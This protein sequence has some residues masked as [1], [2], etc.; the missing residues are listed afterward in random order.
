M[1]WIPFVIFALGLSFQA[2]PVF[3]SGVLVRQ[4]PPSPGGAIS[5]VVIRSTATQAL[6]SYTTAGT[7]ACTL[8]VSKGTTFNPANLVHDVDETLYPGASS[9]LRA[10]NIQNGFGRFALVGRRSAPISTSTLSRLSLALEANATHAYRI[11]CGSGNVATGAFDTANIPFGNTYAES[12][13]GDRSRPGELAQPHL[14]LSDRTDQIIDPQTGVSMRRITANQDIYTDTG[15]V[16]LNILSASPNWSNV[17]N[18]L[19]GDSGAVA[20]ISGQRDALFM[21]VDTSTLPGPASSINYNESG[22][23]PHAA[24]LSY[25]VSIHASVTGPTR[26]IGDNAHVVAS[27]T[28]DGHTPVPNESVH[29]ATL[30]ASLNDATFGTTTP[31][32]LWQAAQAATPYHSQQASRHGVVACDG[33]NK[34]TLVGGD[35]FGEHWN[36][37]SRITIAGTAYVISYNTHT[38]S[39]LLAASC[40]ANASATYS[41][42]NF[43]VL[44][45]KKNASADTLN[46]DYATVSVKA[47]FTYAIGE[48][49]HHY[50]STGTVIGPTGNPG[51]NC[52]FHS[53]NGSNFYWIDS[54]TGESHMWGTTFTNAFVGGSNI[55]FGSGGNNQIFDGNDADRYVAI[56]DGHFL[57]N[58]SVGFVKYWGTHLEPTSVFPFGAGGILRDNAL[59]ACNV[60]GSNA[61][62]YLSQQPCTTYT[63]LTAGTDLFTLTTNFAANPAYS[64]QFDGSKYAGLIFRDIDAQG[65]MQFSFRQTGNSVNGGHAWKVIFDPAATSNVELIAAGQT[66]CRAQAIGAFGCVG[67]G[68]A[69]AIVAAMPIWARPGCRFCED[70]ESGYAAPG[71]A[72]MQTFYP[73]PGPG[74]RPYYVQSVDGA[75]NGT[76][77]SLSSTPDVNCPAN[78]QGI[79]GIHCS[80]ITVTGEPGSRIAEGA[81]T[82]ADG[83]MGPAKVGDRFI[84]AS[85]PSDPKIYENFA[86]NGASTERV[87]LVA[88]DAGA[89]GTW[90]YTLL[91]GQAFRPN[92][93]ATGNLPIFAESCNTIADL[94]FASVGGQVLWNF[95][96]D[97][98]GMNATGNTIPRNYLDVNGHS[99]WANG[100]Y[101]TAYNDGVAPQQYK[102]RIA[103][104]GQTVLDLAS[105]R[106]FTS[107]I[108][109][110]PLFGGVTSGLTSDQYQTHPTNGGDQAVGTRADYF[111]D[112]RPFFGGTASGSNGANGTNPATLVAGARQLW[113]FQP[114]ALFTLDRK[115][116]IYP[117]GAFSGPY[118]LID[119]SGPQSSL[120][121]S[122]VDAFR[123][124]HVIGSGECYPGSLPGQLYVN[125]PHVRYPYS[126]IGV[127]ATGQNLTTEQDLSIGGMPAIRDGVQQIA[128]QPNDSVGATSR[129]ITRNASPRRINQFYTVMTLPNGLFTAQEE[130]LTGD[131]SHNRAIMAVKIPPPAIPDGLDRT[132]FQ[133]ITVLVSPR[134]NSTAYLRFGY[135]ENGDVAFNP[136]TPPPC[137]SRSE[138]C[139]SATLSALSFSV[140]DP[141]YYEATEIFSA[142]EC[143][144]GCSLKIPAISQRVLYYQVIYKDKTSGVLTALPVAV[145]VVA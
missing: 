59:P 82:G 120:S 119:V 99:F 56:G 44:I 109:N 132:T 67:G 126:Y 36:T 13:F 16:S 18:A 55:S 122:D 54:A 145:V 139:V 45:S 73:F 93:L 85:G 27:L 131:R 11:D 51:F 8:Q 74:G 22:Y 135:A 137:T 19:P 133:P 3:R 47:G 81:Q 79:T 41:A 91:R 77:N 17:A 124:C 123:Y 40:P 144:A 4:G 71:W 102:T 104:P 28:M 114:V 1:N 39:L 68:N 86:I 58:L 48:G 127:Q 32:D 23:D 38:A 29:E 33:T 111:L 9:D 34:I 103:Q 76:A 121:D 42:N 6:F 25:Q 12:Q 46:V 52:Q 5:N 15:P 21:A 60:G 62:P 37:G 100:R 106:A 112:G 43:G 80:R 108:L 115:R 143:S 118:P 117:T 24:I 142:A 110:L 83:E 49:D 10:G 105:L 113:L 20:S 95:G 88:K 26:L 116:K 69:G 84:V 94:T 31:G 87:E 70:K 35:T 75:A 129:V 53:G 140:T 97:P 130:Y 107:G 101:A 134:P 98:H 65:R 128:Y 2:P 96:A 72:Y 57:P 138:A 7:A 125:A 78:D 64:P 63:S 89:A 61:P 14:S 50:C 66:D 92:I 90:I 30:S 136:D 141:F